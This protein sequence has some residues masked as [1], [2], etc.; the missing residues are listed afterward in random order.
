ME[1]FILTVAPTGNVP[2]REMNA[3]VPLTP[4]EIGLT[5]GNVYNKG[6]SII[7]IHARDKQFKPTTN[8]EVFQKITGEINKHCPDLIIQYSTGARGGNTAQE[9][10]LPLSLSPE[11]ASLSTGSSNF[12][13]RV[14]FNPPELIEFLAKTMQEKGIK[15]ELEI[16]DT[17]MIHNA[18]FYLEK[19]ILTSPLHFNLVVNVPGSIKGSPKNLL[20]LTENLPPDCTFSVTA[21]GKAHLYMLTL[22][23]VLGGHVRVGLEDTLFLHD[24]TPASNESLVEQILQV[25][26]SLGKEPASPSE[27]RKILTL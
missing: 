8:P 20:F 26:H 1:K 17:S 22:A 23:L 5:A 18:L 3:N 24:G 14:N 10:S 4:E 27:A 2:T 15:P 12:Y 13:D 19:G 6:A 11:M 7:H 21:I 16:F 9:R 25:A